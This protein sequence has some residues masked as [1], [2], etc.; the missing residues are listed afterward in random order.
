MM[1]LSGTFFEITSMP[2]FIEP[3]IK[4]LPLTYVNDALRQIMVAGTPLHSMTTDIGR[5][6]GLGRRLP[7][8]HGT[9][10]P[11][12]LALLQAGC[13]VPWAGPGRGA[14]TVDS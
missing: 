3:L 9:L 1:I 11:L 12:G 2:S 4:I 10:L 7:G 8:R 14:G 5:P 13:G 6:G